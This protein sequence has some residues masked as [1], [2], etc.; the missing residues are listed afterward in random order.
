[1]TRINSDG[2]RFEAIAQAAA[3]TKVIPN[4]DR[5]IGNMGD[6]GSNTSTDRGVGS[7]ESGISAPGVTPVVTLL[8]YQHKQREAAQLAAIA[9][10]YLALVLSRCLLSALLT[11]HNHTTSYRHTIITHHFHLI[12][13]SHFNHTPSCYHTTTIPLFKALPSPCSCAVSIVRRQQPTDKGYSIAHH[14]RSRQ[15]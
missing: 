2:G 1:M 6:S 12:I 14:C 4:T 5:G 3:E 9:Q 7:S 13:L 15:C 10:V 11:H 8:P